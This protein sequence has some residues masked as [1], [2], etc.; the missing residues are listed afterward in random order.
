M[1]VGVEQHAHKQQQALQIQLEAQLEVGLQVEDALAPL[2]GLLIIIVMT[3][4]TTMSAAM[5]VET[6]A[7]VMFTQ[8]GAQYVHALIQMQAGVEQLAH[9]LQQQLIIQVIM[10]L[11]FLNWKKTCC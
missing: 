4:I 8:T 6:V 2:H 10:Q 7:D 3:S 9:L 11:L 1:E 5:M